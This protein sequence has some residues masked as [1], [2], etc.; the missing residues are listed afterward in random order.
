MER[1]FSQI[2]DMNQ[3][4]G[5]DDL[6][7]SIPI[8][9]LLLVQKHSILI[10][11]I[12]PAIDEKI[13]STEFETRFLDRVRFVTQRERDGLLQDISDKISAGLPASI[14]VGKLVAN[15][16]QPVFR[17]LDGYIANIVY[18]NQKFPGTLEI[19]NSW[20]KWINDGEDGIKYIEYNYVNYNIFSILYSEYLDVVSKYERFSDKPWK[21]L[22]KEYKIISI[23]LNAHD[24][25]FKNYKLLSYNENFK[26]VSDKDSRTLF[27]HRLDRYLWVDVP[28]ILLDDFQELIARDFIKDISF[29]IDYIS[30]YVPALE[31]MEFGCPF[32]FQAMSLPVI[33]KLYNINSYND[34]LW[35]KKGE[36]PSNLTFEEMIENYSSLDGKIITQV[37]HL[38]FFISDENYYINH[39]DHE[40]I[41]YSMDEY[42][43]RLS[44]PSV[45]GKKRKTFKI[46]GA[47]IPFD[48]KINDRYFLYSI[49]DAY[50]VNKE[51][52]S[53]YFDAIN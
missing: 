21:N 22:E 47:K 35:V 5:I 23:D 51:L 38:E 18:Q 12:F 36:N 43:I 9:A 49:L 53:E 44:D 26:I 31:E 1:W 13:Y 45:K 34:A 25:Q 6:H 30:Q 10:D 42:N 28:K 40:Y 4:R 29:R 27:D 19:I 32:S 14:S 17:D 37:I 7:R 52:I 3:A 33:S 39:V 46:D 2:R 16:A 11:Q 20:Y 48:F 50:F 41:L 24:A 15:L 8:G